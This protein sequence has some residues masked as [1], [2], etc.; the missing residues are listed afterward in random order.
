VLTADLGHAGEMLDAQAKAT[1]AKIDRLEDESK[2]A[3]EL[4]NE[5]VSGKPKKRRERSRARS[6]APLVLPAVTG[7]QLPVVNAL[8]SR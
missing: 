4:G 8:G 6:D 1:I 5:N 2:K 3:R 7:G